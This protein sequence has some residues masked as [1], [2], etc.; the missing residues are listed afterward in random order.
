MEGP[1]FFFFGCFCDVTKSVM[2]KKKVR[3]GFLVFRIYGLAEIGGLLTIGED[4]QQ[5]P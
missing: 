4:D 5:A 2:L 3:P 1:F